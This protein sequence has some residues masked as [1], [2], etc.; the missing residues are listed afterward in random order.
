MSTVPG[1]SAPL[2]PEVTHADVIEPKPTTPW[3]PMVPHRRAVAVLVALSMGGFLFV[4]NEIAPYG[5]IKLMA[6]D[7]GRTES[8]IGLLVTGF[9]LVIVAASVP[10]AVFTRRIPRRYLLTGALVAYAVGGVLVATSSNMGGLLAGR[11]VQALGQAMFW[12]VVNSTAVALFP[13]QIR[14]KIIARVLIG[15]SA[16][17]VVGLPSITRLGQLTEWQM[18]F[19]ILAGVGTLLAAV[20]FLLIPTYKPD[21]GSG[22]RGSDPHRRRFVAVLIVVSLS[23]GSTAITYTYITPFLVDVTGIGQTVVP[24]VLLVGGAFS[25]LGTLVVGRF[26]DRYPVRTVA[27]ALVMLLGVWGALWAGGAT[28]WVAVGVVLVQGF[29]WSLFVAAGNNRIM[30][31][32]PGS[33][34]IG[35]ATNASM[36]NTGTAVGSL[37]GAGILADAGAELLP[38]ASLAGV[39]LAGAVLALEWRSLRAGVRAPRARRLISR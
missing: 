14:G 11:L 37:I 36:Y 8:E 38:L 3:T 23:A 32:A 31:H 34:D 19:W 15:S 7:L 4:T 16:A 27:V 1:S 18:P 24:T 5:L 20:Y 13:P 25:L 33:T 9:A 2:P 39:M 21:E 30:R 26:L 22:A 6:A 28:A 12:A 35:I 17:G 29:A 10:L